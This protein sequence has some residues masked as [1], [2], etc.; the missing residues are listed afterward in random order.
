MHHTQEREQ[1]IRLWLDHV[2]AA[3]RPGIFWSSLLLMPF[4][5]K[6]GAPSTTAPPPIRHWFQEWN[7]RGRVEVWDSGRFFHREDA[8][9]VEWRFRCVMND[10]AVQTFDGLSLVEWTQE[11]TIRRLQEFWLQ[12]GHL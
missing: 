2:A 9:I 12:P 11:G 8:T 7:T 5:L 1:K 4:I 10:G 3:G 6:A